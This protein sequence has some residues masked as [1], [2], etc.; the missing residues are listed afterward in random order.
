MNTTH[1]WN[2]QAAGISLGTGRRNP[3][4]ALL[5]KTPQPILNVT[6]LTG[7]DGCHGQ[8]WLV[9][10]GGSG[11]ETR[12]GRVERRAVVPVPAWQHTV[13]LLHSQVGVAR[14][15]V[16][17]GGYRV[18]ADGRPVRCGDNLLLHEVVLVLQAREAA[19]PQRP[20]LFP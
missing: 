6:L 14:L 17:D 10:G 15:P 4:T 20:E 9:C 18:T 3:R 8:I 16:V 11:R 12:C 5:V 7:A 1:I 19:L 13:C 2:S